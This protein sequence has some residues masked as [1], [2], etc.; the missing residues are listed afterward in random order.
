VVND[1]H[2]QLA[3]RLFHC[4]L[5]FEDLVSGFNRRVGE[6]LVSGESH[7]SVN[8]P[9][10]SVLPVSRTNRM[11]ICLGHACICFCQMFRAKLMCACALLKLHKAPH[12][13]GHPE[14]PLGAVQDPVPFSQAINSHRLVL[15]AGRSQNS[16]EGHPNLQ[17]DSRLR[18]NCHDGVT[19]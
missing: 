4:A 8:L 13:T 1:G 19:V 11:A 9:S 5:R 2:E 7:P 6:I 3:D 14:D 18:R 10:G 17:T 15:P 12:G 16:G